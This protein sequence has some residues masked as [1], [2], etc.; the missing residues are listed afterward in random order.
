MSTYTDIPS[1]RFMP[2]VKELLQNLKASGLPTNERQ[3]ALITVLIVSAVADKR[4]KDAFI[5][6]LAQELGA[7]WDA[8]AAWV[9]AIKERQ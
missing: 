2:L 9:Q 3:A 6:G 4:E 7:N 1:E 8:I 5:V